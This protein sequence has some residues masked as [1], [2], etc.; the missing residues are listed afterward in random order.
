MGE[1]EEKVIALHE[2]LLENIPDGWRGNGPKEQ[3]VKQAI[4]AIVEN[5]A[6]VERLF[7][8]INQQVGY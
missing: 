3:R 8:I 7:A 4:Y 6:E 1:N 2:H 5:K